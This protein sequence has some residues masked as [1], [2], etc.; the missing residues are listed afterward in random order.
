[1][2][3]KSDRGH[4]LIGEVTSLNGDTV[5]VDT[6]PEGRALPTGIQVTLSVGP[7]GGPRVESPGRCIGRM[8]RDG[9]RIYCFRVTP[10]EPTGTTATETLSELFNRR[11]AAR[12]RL[13]HILAAVCAFKDGKVDVNARLPVRM[14]D[15]SSSGAAFA[16]ELELE[17][18]LATADL[19]GLRFRLSAPGSDDAEV[20]QFVS[21][22]RRR[23][24][25][26]AEEVVY[27]V[28]FDPSRTPHFDRN[29]E[30]LR[31]Y[32]EV[33]SEVAERLF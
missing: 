1:M 6:P 20:V 33:Q 14:I 23:R 12:V 5:T 17:E 7:R 11:W 2:T 18:R 10:D 32:T 19:V 8:D 24:M 4:F 22:V 30:F 25:E 16:V 27:G 26:G 15:V 28:E 29:I 9:S 21:R 3:I 13:D 31:R